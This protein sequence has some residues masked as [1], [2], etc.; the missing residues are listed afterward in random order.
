MRKIVISGA[1]G[2]DGAYLI[3]AL[4]QRGDVTITA[5]V[6]RCAR[7]L[8]PD[9]GVDVLEGDIRDSGITQRIAALK[10]DEIYNL[11]ALSHV[12]HSFDCPDD[13]IQTNTLGCLHMLEA[14]KQSGAR[15][16]QASTSEIFGNSPSP[17]SE[18]TPLAPASPYAIA[19]VAAYH[20]VRLYREAYGVFACNG[21]LFNHESPR[22]GADFVTQ[23]VCMAVA[24]IARGEQDKLR[25]G[26]LSARRDW[27]HAADYARGMVMMLRC[28]HPGDY[29]LATGISRTVAEL[30]EAAFGVVGISDWQRYVETDDDL[31][32]PLDVQHLRGDAS[33]ARITLGWEP[34][35]TFNDMIEEMVRAQFGNQYVDRR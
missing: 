6:R 17:Q 20:L 24:R 34:T 13:V 29:V 4:R 21:I 35:T 28:D 2:Q 33:K 8:N 9:L 3:E 23:K 15:F 16:Y 30:C 26:N 25:L 32:R 27:G 14:A 10:P 1:T 19:K 31:K 12:G 18:I 5:L 7:D 11:A 22:R